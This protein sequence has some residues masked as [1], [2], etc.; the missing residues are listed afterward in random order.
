MIIKSIA[1]F[2]HDPYIDPTWVYRKDVDEGKP[3][4]AVRVLHDKF[5]FRKFRVSL[6]VDKRELEQLLIIAGDNKK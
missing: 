6:Y 1:G 4:T 5:D 2:H 3:A